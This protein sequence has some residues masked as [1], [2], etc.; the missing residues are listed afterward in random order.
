MDKLK[1]FKDQVISKLLMYNIMQ[2]KSR[3]EHDTVLNEER[4]DRIIGV[5]QVPS[6]TCMYQG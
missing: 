3:E 4:L 5:L 1:E 6:S 2:A